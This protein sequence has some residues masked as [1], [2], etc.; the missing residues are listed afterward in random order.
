MFSFSG[1]YPSLRGVIFNANTGANLDAN[2]QPFFTE[3]HQGSTHSIEKVS[4][5][6]DPI[7]WTVPLGVIFH[8]IRPPQAD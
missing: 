6:V 7:Y 8:D 2:Q 5:E 3:L 1:G 4:P